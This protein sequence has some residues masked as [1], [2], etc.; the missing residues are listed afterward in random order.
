MTILHERDDEKIFF[1]FD[2]NGDVGKENKLMI[3]KAQETL[4]EEALKKRD[5]VIFMPKES[6]HATDIDIFCT[7]PVKYPTS[8]MLCLSYVNNSGDNILIPSTILFQIARIFF[9][10]SSALALAAKS[11]QMVCCS[12][13]ARVTS[14]T[15]M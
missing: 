7:L 8:G 10:A 12:N 15:R 6:N 14:T 3:G 2:K 11:R 1:P 4:L 13:G 9:C 5:A